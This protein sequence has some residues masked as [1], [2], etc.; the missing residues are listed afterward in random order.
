MDTEHY[1]TRAII[2][3]L[4]RIFNLLGA[5][6]NS[7]Y[8]ETPKVNRLV[9]SGGESESGHKA[10]MD[11][12]FLTDRCVACKGPDGDGGV[13]F[14]PSLYRCC[15]LLTLGVAGLCPSC[16][17]S[18]SDVAYALMART[19]EVHVRRQAAHAIC[20]SCEG[21]P[22]GDPVACV[23]FDCPTLYRR[24]QTDQEVGR[25]EALA[26]LVEKLGQ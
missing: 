7:W 10:L 14:L 20:A 16:L 5:D 26:E 21:T 17:N 12:H 18:P 6:V 1:I 9:V 2:P 3:P 8:T 23:S 22:H 25:I 24:I 15:F 11:E 19:R 4:E 13:F